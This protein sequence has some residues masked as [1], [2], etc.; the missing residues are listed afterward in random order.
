M[1]N[2]ELQEMDTEFQMIQYRHQEYVSL[3]PTSRLYTLS[4][5]AVVVDGTVLD[6][7][8]NVRISIENQICHD[9]F[10]TL[11]DS[12]QP[13]VLFKNGVFN[14]AACGFDSCIVLDAR[15]LGLKT[16]SA[17]IGKVHNVKR[18]YL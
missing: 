6:F 9:S 4:Y 11:W 16:L 2:L 13:G 14:D 12:C 3:S 15:N 5:F 7:G 10:D 18:V 17:Q 1:P 8:N